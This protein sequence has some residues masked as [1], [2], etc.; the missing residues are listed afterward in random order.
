MLHACMQRPPIQ[1]HVTDILYLDMRW[2][3]F[4]ESC[5]PAAEYIIT[6]AALDKIVWFEESTGPAHTRPHA[7][8][9]VIIQTICRGA[10]WWWSAVWCIANRAKERQATSAACQRNEYE[11]AHATCRVNCRGSVVGQFLVAVCGLV[12]CKNRAK[13]SANDKA[14]SAAY[15]RKEHEILKNRERDS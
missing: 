13:K 5:S 1:D 6:A 14:L 2:S 11:K 15:Q 7:T 12:H 9:R 4:A 3:F 8:C 10:V